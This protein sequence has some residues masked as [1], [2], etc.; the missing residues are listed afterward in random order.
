MRQLRSLERRNTKEFF[1]K[2]PLQKLRS[3][4]TSVAE[5]AGML[6]LALVQSGIMDIEKI[7]HAGAAIL[8]RIHP[9]VKKGDNKIEPIAS[10]RGTNSVVRLKAKHRTSI[11][12]TSCLA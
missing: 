10:F 9:T 11:C 3:R 4:S 5:P 1:L 7:G 6:S 8:V 12:T 2:Q